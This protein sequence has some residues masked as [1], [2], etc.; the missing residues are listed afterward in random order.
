M[1][2][3]Y[4]MFVGITWLHGHNIM[5][6][7]CCCVM[8]WAICVGGLIIHISLNGQNPFP[9]PP[10]I[11]QSLLVSIFG[12]LQALPTLAVFTACSV[13]MYEYIVHIHYTYLVLC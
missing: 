7:L 4:Q 12:F 3:D 5:W 6:Y 8:L 11:S 13:T 10:A 2:L 1:G 9:P